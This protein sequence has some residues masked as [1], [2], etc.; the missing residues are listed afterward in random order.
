MNSIVLISCV[1]VMLTLSSTTAKK[2]AYGQSV[3][4][5]KDKC[6]AIG[7]GPKGMKDGST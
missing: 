2:V 3:W 7:V 5:E 4:L 1:F 6:T